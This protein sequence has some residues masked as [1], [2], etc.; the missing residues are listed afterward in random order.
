VQEQVPEPAD[1]NV[2]EDGHAI[3]DPLLS[4]DFYMH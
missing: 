4:N 1:E 3:H 2:A